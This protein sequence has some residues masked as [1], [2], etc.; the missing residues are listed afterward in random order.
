MFGWLKNLFKK[1]QDPYTSSER[2]IFTFWNGVKWVRG[3]PMVLYKRMMD[4]G[5]SL[6]INM[7][8]ADSPS[9]AAGKAHD[10]MMMQIRGIFGLKPL[11]GV[12]SNGTLTD[13]RAQDLLSDFMEFCDT[14]KKNSRKSPTT[15][16]PSEESKLTSGAAPPISNTSDSGST[17]DVPSTA[18]PEPSLM[19]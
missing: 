3:D 11:D 7:K 4:V 1:K 6:S 15:S 18:S 2:E 19:A 17:A 12:D 5:P 16:K 8:V 14:V 10:D 13:S 9:N